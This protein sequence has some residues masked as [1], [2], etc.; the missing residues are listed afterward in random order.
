M[1]KNPYKPTADSIQNQAVALSSKDPGLALVL[2][3]ANANALLQI[4]RVPIRIM[5]VSD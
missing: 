1:T 2:L 4:L 5:L 3:I